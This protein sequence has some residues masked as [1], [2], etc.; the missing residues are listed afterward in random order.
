MHVPAFSRAS[1][2][3]HPACQIFLTQHAGQCPTDMFPSE[4]A[5][6]LSSR[7][8]SLIHRTEDQARYDKLRDRMARARTRG[9]DA[10]TE[11]E[12]TAPDIEEAPQGTTA[13]K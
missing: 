10:S 4:Q 11:T 8:R 7:V 1:S 5:D 12:T 9:G 13:E 6:A 3:P 2:D